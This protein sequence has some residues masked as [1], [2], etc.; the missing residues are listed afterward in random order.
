MSYF[1]QFIAERKDEA[2]NTYVGRPMISN[3]SNLEFRKGEIY[4]NGIKYNGQIRIHGTSP[5]HFVYPKK[6]YAIKLEND[7][8]IKNMRR[9]SLT[10]LEKPAISSI[11]SY[12]ISKLF[13]FM[14]VNS[15]L[16]K[17][18]IND[19]LQGVYLLEE[20]LHKVLLEKNNLSNVDVIKPVDNYDHQ[21]PNGNHEHPYVYDLSNTQIKRISEKNIG[22]VL[23][24]KALYDK[25]LNLPSIKKIIDV[26]KFAKFDALRILF[27]DS[28]QILG[29]NQ[30]ILYDTS[31][32][33]LMPFFRT[34]GI[35]MSLEN[36]NY[37]SNFDKNVYNL[38]NNPKFENNSL[39]KIL[40]KNDQYRILRNN[41]LYE[42][43]Q[44]KKEII[45]LYNDTM[46]ELI[47]ILRASRGPNYSSRKLIFNEYS[48]YEKIKGNLNAIEKYLNYSKVF[49]E[50]INENGME[51]DISL[52]PDSNSGVYV[53]KVQSN[54]L[55]DDNISIQ[56]KDGVTEY[57]T[58]KELGPS[59]NKE[60]LILGLDNDLD[61]IKKVVKYNLK[62]DKIITSLKFEFSNLVTKKKVA[63]KNVATIFIDKPKEFSF[64]Y[65]ES[66]IGQFLSKNSD[67]NL[68]IKERDVFLPEGQYHL[69]SN[70]IVPY[71]YNLI[72]DKGV[73]IKINSDKS[74]LIYG[75]FKVEGTRLKP[76]TISNMYKDSAFGTVAAIGNGKSESVINHLYLW[77]GSNANIN[78][79][80]LSGALSLYNHDSVEVLNSEVFNNSGDDGLNIKNS[81]VFLF[82]NKFHG[83]A[84]DQVDIDVSDGLIENNKFL[85]KV[86]KNGYH[87]N[88]ISQ[89]NNGDG[90][91][92][93]GSHVKIIKNYF[94]GFLDK[95]IS[96][97]ENTTALVSNNDFLNNSSAITAKDQSKVYIS[98][99][100]YISN[101]IDIQM[102]RKKPIFNSPSV[103]DF[104]LETGPVKNI[105]KTLDSQYYK[106]LREDDKKVFVVDDPTFHDLSK[107]NWTEV[108]Q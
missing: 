55:P 34:E 74:I 62:S 103:F 4:Y 98:S 15:Y 87:L 106:L 68:T 108:E 88:R 63:V 40:V 48:N 41:Y 42:I 19:K 33:M 12:K 36:N 92:F 2:K 89:D 8:L 16:V 35:V 44:R 72:I 81:K 23:R 59:L 64:D 67:L 43:I 94:E 95:A 80:H 99:N 25:S 90:A 102:Y 38:I 79:A 6:S 14:D 51:V 105:K 86:E 107:A 100:N 84:A 96:I 61:V 93:S 17:L 45:S 37:G 29:A 5:W 65:L 3:N 58:M 46:N 47:P 49:V 71:G 26:D 9:F 11:A 31:T 27:G 77:G 54:L 28:H 53:S 1:K 60:D 10:N 32:G 7:G 39:Y 91:D 21:Y 18:K 97:G 70:L 50:V 30:K 73:D 22:Q 56:K 85:S 104:N 13:G 24:Y 101:D 66:D 82:N 20:K 83:N 57:I 76:V 69:N 78:G 75:G 52:G